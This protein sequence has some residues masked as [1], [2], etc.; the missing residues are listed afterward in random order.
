MMFALQA[1]T[2]SQER[3][4]AYPAT[5]LVH[6]V[7]T[8]PHALIAT[9]LLIVNMQQ[10]TALLLMD[11]MTMALWRLSPVPQAARHA[12][13]VIHVIAVFLDGFHQ[14]CFVRAIVMTQIVMT[15]CLTFRTVQYVY[16]DMTSTRVTCAKWFVKIQTV[17][18]VQGIP[19]F[20]FNA[21]LVFKLA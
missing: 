18:I 5:I 11:T 21:Q 19:Q 3:N 4:C 15:V 17:Q 2:Q 13:M 6:I 20:V 12:A 7:Q 9:T 1:I 10:V 14:V 8:L 16:L